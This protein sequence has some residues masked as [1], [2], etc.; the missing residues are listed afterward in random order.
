L[1]IILAG[2]LK[3]EAIMNKQKGLSLIEIVVVIV[4]IT[5]FLLLF[6][7]IPAPS[8]EGGPRVICL[9]NLKNLQLAWSLYA[10]SNNGKIVCG[11]TYSGEKGTNGTRKVSDGNEP[12]WAGDDVTDTLSEKQLSQETKVSA[13]KSGALYPYL[14]T[15]K[16]YRCPLGDKGEMHTCAIGDSMN[17]TSRGLED[18]KFGKI[19]LYIKNIAEI[20]SPAERIVFIDVGKATAGSFATYYDKEQWWNPAPLRHSRGTN[21]SFADG[22]AEYW[23]WT[24]EET[25][26]NGRSAKPKQDL[27]PTTQ[28]GLEDLHKFQKGVWGRL[29]Y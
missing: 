9:A 19:T 4:A 1:F 29:G 5:V 16:P 14:K 8:R 25:I 12:Y 7:R 21:L 10:E 27:Q 22:H 28:A 6:L 3:R 17:G 13:I 2:N 11:E 18:K 15:V 23:R 24:G 26:T 20:A